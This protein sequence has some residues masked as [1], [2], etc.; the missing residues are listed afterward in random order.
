MKHFSQS[1]YQKHLYS[2]NHRKQILYAWYINLCYHY[3]KRH[4]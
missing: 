3:E 2:A 1:I 4:P